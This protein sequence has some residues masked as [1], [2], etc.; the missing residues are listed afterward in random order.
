MQGGRK[1][2]VPLALTVTRETE[3]LFFWYEEVFII[4]CQII[5]MKWTGFAFAAVTLLL[6]I[7]TIGAAESPPQGEGLASIRQ[8]NDLVI[9]EKEQAFK[10]MRIAGYDE[11]VEELAV[12]IDLSVLE[13]HGVDVSSAGIT[14]PDE[15][16]DG[17]SVKSAIVKKG[18]MSLVFSPKETGI[19]V[20]EFRLTGLNTSDAQ[21]ATN[22]N[23][24][25]K[26]SS[27]DAEG[28]SF[29]IV[30]ADDVKPRMSAETLVLSEGSQWVTIQRLQPTGGNVTVELN[31]TIL[32]EYGIGLDDIEAKV[33][34]D[35]ATVQKASVDDG[36]IRVVVSPAE[37]T[38]L[39]NVELF[40]TGF[41]TTSVNTDQDTIASDVRYQ[42]RLEGV[43]ND[44]I[45]RETFD[46][47]SNLPSPHVDPSPTSTPVHTSQPETT[48]S[49]DPPISDHGPEMWPVGVLVTLLVIAVLAER[50]G[51][52]PER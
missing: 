3:T 33:R 20:S 47:L 51:L 35:D 8:I 18:V 22:L 34:T 19:F 32:Q 4:T 10:G 49:P 16:V 6:L 40:L 21:V 23:Y 37:D 13:R 43:A 15:N 36:V 5:Y 27:G 48:D 24:D 31:A 46:I 12:E 30:N 28:S 14:I 9:G 25:M 52:G 1:F 29:D 38:V 7:S 17:A 26:F 50:R 42:L 39:L 11:D 41:N 45:Q 44:D 2:G